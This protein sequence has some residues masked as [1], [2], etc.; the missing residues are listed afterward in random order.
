MA[1]RREVS[2][3]PEGSHE[4]LGAG[5]YIDGEPID[6]ESLDE[7]EE[8]ERL[9]QEAKDKHSR[10]KLPAQSHIKSY[11]TILTSAL[12]GYDYSA[13]VEP[14]PY[15][16][17]EEA[18]LCL[19][20]I[21]KWFRSHDMRSNSSEVAIACAESGILQDLVTI[22]CMW[23]DGLDDPN[24]T[25]S[26]FSK[27]HD[28][29]IARMCM[30]LLVMLTWPVELKSGMHQNQLENYQS[31]KKHQLVY[32]HFILTYRS[33]AVLQAIIKLSI[34]IITKDK[35]DR[36]AGDYNI[37]KQCVA[38]F[39]NLLQIEPPGISKLKLKSNKQ[40]SLTEDLPRGI[41]PDDVN[42]G[43]CI[44]AFNDN[45]VFTFFLTMCSSIGNDRDFDPEILALVFM[46]IIYLM[47][48]TLR[49]SYIM[50]SDESPNSSVKSSTG[51]S[52]LL[53]EEKAMVNKFKKNSSSR[54]GRFGTL[55]S[56]Q[57]PDMGR[58][59]MSNTGNVLGA[60]NVITSFDAHKKWNKTR[61]FLYEPDEEIVFPEIAIGSSNRKSFYSFVCDFLDGAFNPFIK[62]C[63]KVQTHHD[64]SGKL[65]DVERNHFF[66]LIAWFLE[67]QRERYGSNISEVDYTLVGNAFTPEVF[68]LLHK[69]M[70]ETG[71]N[72]TSRR[73]GKG[74]DQPASRYGL[75]HSTLI[76]FKEVIL[77]ANT[78]GVS[79]MADNRDLSV[80]L[81][82]QLF[83]TSK[84]YLDALGDISKFAHKRSPE[85][86]TTLV[87]TLDVTIR[88]LEAYHRADMTAF[89][90]NEKSKSRVGPKIVDEEQVVI[91]EID[92]TNTKGV[93]KGAENLANGRKSVRDKFVYRLANPEV[94]NAYVAHI[95]R[96]ND[97]SD[98]SL[99]KAIKFLHKVF[100]EL[101][102]EPLLYRID[103]MITLH[104]ML[105]DEGLPKTSNNRKHVESFLNHF[106]R[107]FKKALDKTPALYVEVLFPMTKDK[108]MSTYLLTGEIP[109]PSHKET[110]A[111]VANSVV[112]FKNG[113]DLDLDRKVALL[114]G[115]MI[116]DQLG[117]LVSWISQELE[118]IVSIRMPS[119]ADEADDTIIP[120]DIVIKSDT[121]EYML[122]L[123][124]E[125][126]LRL[127]LKLAGVVV[128]STTKEECI[129]HENA[130]LDQ[131]IA[132]N[133]SIKVYLIT[134]VPV[135]DGMT[136]GDYMHTRFVLHDQK[137][138]DDDY[139]IDELAGAGYSSDED[140]IAF[141]TNRNRDSDDDGVGYMDNEL[142]RLEAAIEQGERLQSGSG[143]RGVA[144]R[145]GGKNKKEK[146]SKE[147]KSRR[148]KKKRS[149]KDLAL[150]VLSD[151][152]SGSSSKKRKDPENYKSM[153][154]I[155]DS[156]D[157]DDEAFFER[158]NML[159]SLLEESG[160]TLSLHQLKRMLNS[161]GSTVSVKE[162]TTSVSS[163]L[164]LADTSIISATKRAGE[165][166]ETESPPSK[167]MRTESV[168]TETE[169]ALSVS[170]SDSDGDNESSSGDGSDSGSDSDS[171]DGSD[172][173]NSEDN[174]EDEGN[175]EGTSVE[176]V[177]LEKDQEMAESD[178]EEEDRRT[179]VRASKKRAIITD[180][181]EE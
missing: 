2:E 95:K 118:R 155:L 55:L 156:D 34:P 166:N 94:I 96:F 140:D 126:R 61:K 133:T 79:S 116:D 43:A 158:E 106:M 83:S 143:V 97:I 5:D 49:P 159:R 17:G 110:K 127:L 176:P 18:F 107:K 30:K 162:G 63:T 53:A 165:E 93:A 13:D 65:T 60:N 114:V 25:I 29:K 100:F 26:G 109:P 64:E 48:K 152:E 99:K 144:N 75:A 10:R 168:V 33:G 131:L 21:D 57:T 37:I 111:V 62:A 44:G 148:K 11:I 124:T 178:G 167:R 120:K 84:F 39:R 54:H 72:P 1:K 113:D 20:D 69:A 28:E 46:D 142:D 171:D 51:L 136:A 70:T 56:L 117:D 16:L 36:E 105:A 112:E 42:I 135:D 81:Q 82:K 92:E 31:V 125:P 137:A 146:K 141:N 40:S 134:P 91:A 67:A 121:P 85:F 160:G 87:D 78:M 35:K 161:K 14:A 169:D 151:D 132:V 145:K 89:I 172:K 102:R 101:K 103:F 12:G 153:E 175:T 23:N 52:A 86:I 3:D 98:K 32:K 41:S 181:D 104:S 47:L 9:A 154:Y 4:E 80:S 173:E 108:E 115:A 147:K 45:L 130:D 59:T 177:S 73:V 138:R 139:D 150:H 68:I 50:Q 174:V 163:D 128:P 88:E 7:E 66:L 164:N 77:V 19:Q 71:S 149:G 22:M 58:L 74:E 15:K 123:V 157:E 76:L 6:G 170:E 119:N 129:F 38:F 24:T 90:M 27:R 180:S 8:L 179:V 122:K